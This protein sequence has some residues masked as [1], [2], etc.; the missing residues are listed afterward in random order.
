MR[1]NDSNNELEYI[2][3]ERQLWRKTIR[4]I[5]VKIVGSKDCFIRSKLISELELN[6]NPMDKEDRDLIQC[7]K[8]IR[9]QGLEENDEKYKKYKKELLERTSLLLK[10][11]WERA[12]YE[13]R[14]SR[15]NINGLYGSIITGIIIQS[16]LYEFLVQIQTLKFIKTL[17]GNDLIFYILTTIISSYI[18]YNLARVGYILITAEANTTKSALINKILEGK[19][20]RET[21]SNFRSGQAP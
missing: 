18:V 1:N 21:F 16:V 8:K 6:L 10:H 5:S 17:I 3:K 11:D 2:T 7:A 14:K 19:P 9:C 13:S 4:E 15:V 20:E 12:K